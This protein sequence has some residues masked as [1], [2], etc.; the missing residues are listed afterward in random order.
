MYTTT[1]IIA[2]LERLAEPH[3]RNIFIKH[4]A[5]QPVYGVRTEALKNIQK[6]IKKNYMLSMELYDTGIHEAMY[7]AG[8]IADE[9]R[10]T[11]ADLQKWVE[12]SK[13]PIISEYTVAWIT[14]ESV[15]GLSL[16]LSWI[17]SDQELIASSGWSTLAS[18]CSIID[19]AHLDRALMLALL[20][21]VHRDIHTAPNRVRYTMNNFVI[22][23]GSF[24]P[25]YTAHALQVA[26][27]IGTVH[28]DVGDTACQIP[29]AGAYIQKVI[30]KGYLGKKKKQARC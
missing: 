26:S 15:F 8:L 28:V 6:R 5:Q 2:E 1:E 17:D 23:L 13:S 18:V 9:Q 21:R 19:N 3:I 14:A 11:I 12:Q 30:D 16:G 10:M 7:L 27:D 4:G 24:V 20:D 29:T 22:A 25:S